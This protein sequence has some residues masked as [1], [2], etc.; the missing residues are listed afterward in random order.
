MY[1]E[2]DKHVSRQETDDIY[3]NISSAKKLVIY[4]FAGHENY[5]KRYDKEWTSD[6][7]LFLS[8]LD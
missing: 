1:G 6:V 3:N 7:H 2:K 5:L 8:G 4:P